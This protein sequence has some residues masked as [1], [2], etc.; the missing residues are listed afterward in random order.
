MSHEIEYYTYKDGTDLKKICA[1]IDEHV[2]HA[3]YREGG[4]GLIS[5][6]R[7]IDQV[8]ADYD[9]AMDYIKGHDRG[10]YDQLAVKFRKL[11]HG[12]TTKKIDELNKKIKA[13]RQEYYALNNEVPAKTFKAEYVGCRHCG[14]KINRTYIKSNYC[15]VC[16]GDMRSETILNKLDA[17]RKKIE[18]WSADLQVEERKLAEKYGEIY[19]LV[20]IEYHK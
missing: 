13:A 5:A 16:H 11:P 12:K 8:M 6:I 3:T 9:D 10:N 2:R 20:K 7:F 14:S 19:W 1:G 15:P 17:L 4:H 18:R